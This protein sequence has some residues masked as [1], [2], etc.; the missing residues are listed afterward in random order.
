MRDNWYS[1]WKKGLVYKVSAGIS[2][3]NLPTGF[4]NVCK[5]L[6]SNATDSQ[7]ILMHLLAKVITLYILTLLTNP[8]STHF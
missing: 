2:E 6:S 7:F 5:L 8:I 3:E 1:L 4:A